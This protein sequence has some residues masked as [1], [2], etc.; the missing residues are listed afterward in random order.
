MNHLNDSDAKMTVNVSDVTFSGSV[1]KVNNNSGSGVL[2]AGNVRGN[3]KE[4]ATCEAEVTIDDICFENLKV[5]NCRI[6]YAPLLINTIGNYTTLTVNGITNSYE[7][8][9][10]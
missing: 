10:R 3:K 2:F 8:K 4:N 9:T 1:G 5:T 6:D 7:S